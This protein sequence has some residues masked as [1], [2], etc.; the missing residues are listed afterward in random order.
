MK[1][2]TRRSGTPALPA[3]WRLVIVYVARP[4]PP[5]PPDAVVA[6]A[7]GQRGGER[8]KCRIKPEW[9]LFRG[10]PVGAF[11]LCFHRRLDVAE[12]LRCWKSPESPD[13]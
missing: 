7:V 10:A 9:F 5:P 12:R 2:G 13:P 1:S 6:A 3:T 8:G 11:L 4:P